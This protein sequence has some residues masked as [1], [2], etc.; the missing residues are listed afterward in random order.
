MYYSNY[1]YAQLFPLLLTILECCENPSKHHN[2]IYDKYSERRFK[3]SSLFVE[4][5]IGK[6]FRLME[7]SKDNRFA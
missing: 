2:A 3:R 1:T 5:E 7:P 6:G 4:A